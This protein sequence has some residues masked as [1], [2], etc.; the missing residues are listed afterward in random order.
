MYDVVTQVDSSFLQMFIWE[1]FS[2][3]APKSVEYPAVTMEE[4]T[5]LTYQGG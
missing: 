1:Q 3:G 2:T 4:L 5:L